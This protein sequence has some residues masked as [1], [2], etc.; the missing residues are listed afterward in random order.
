MDCPNCGEWLRGGMLVC[1]RCGRYLTRPVEGTGLPTTFVRTDWRSLP[2]FPAQS[3]GASGRGLMFECGE[4]IFELIF[5][6][7]EGLG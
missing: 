3:S 4:F 1:H 7:L 2:P 5:G 6:I